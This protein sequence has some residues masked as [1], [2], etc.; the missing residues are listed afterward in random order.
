M[1]FICHLPK[2]CD[3]IFCTHKF[4]VACWQQPKKNGLRTETI[5]LENDFVHGNYNYRNS[6]LLSGIP[7][8]WWYNKGDNNNYYFYVPVIFEV[9]TM[10]CIPL[11]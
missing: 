3:I 4:I 8:L 7:Q 6:L 10:H 2:D 5:Y 9:V 11:V 1:L